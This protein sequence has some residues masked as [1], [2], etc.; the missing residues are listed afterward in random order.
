MLLLRTIG[1]REV[2]KSQSN[3]RRGMDMTMRRRRGTFETDFKITGFTLIELLVVISIIALL[4]GI[5]LPALGAARN[6][7]QAIVCAG[8]QRSVGQAMM[9]YS[10]DGKELLPPSYVYPYDEDGN[11]RWRDQFGSGAQRY[12]H[13][14]FIVYGKEGVADGAFT[15]PSL[16]NGGMP[17]TWPGD[18]RDDWQT[19]PDSP[20]DLQAPRMAYAGNSALI[21]RNKFSDNEQSPRKNRLVQVGE[22]TMASNTILAAE[23]SENTHLIRDSVTSKSHRPIVGLRGSGLQAHMEANSSFG[24]GRWYYG[25]SDDYGL[26]PYETLLQ[27]KSGALSQVSQGGPN[28]NAV[29]R[30]HSGGGGSGVGSEGSANF[31]FTDGHVDRSTIRETM[32]SRQW[33]DRMYSVT[34]TD[35]KVYDFNQ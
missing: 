3:K 33:G 32:D 10:T 5:L 1:G 16:D 21:P 4:V 20:V 26:Q 34:G 19:A 8:N 23:Y 11:W 14:S 12:L 22:V 31:L 7:A 24:R 17:R 15:C 27:Q 29:G 18:D 6:S 30:H 35:T 28:I 2:T 25:E 9:A 13:W